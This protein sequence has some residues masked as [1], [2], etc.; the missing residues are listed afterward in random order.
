MQGGRCREGL[1]GGWPAPR[2]A[3]Y[4]L[5]RVRVRVSIEKHSDKKIGE[6]AQKI[7]KNLRIFFSVLLV[8][9]LAFGGWTA[10]TSLSRPP[11]NG[12]GPEAPLGTGHPSN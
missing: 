1:F 5:F 3:V 6:K 12:T 8:V 11:P 10:G 4:P 9:L 7:L 2:G